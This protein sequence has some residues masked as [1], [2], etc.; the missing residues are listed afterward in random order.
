MGDV[1]KVK[2]TAIKFLFVMKIEV[3]S[4]V[5]SL[6]AGRILLIKWS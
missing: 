5:L 6:K 4:L 3:L 1:I 2:K